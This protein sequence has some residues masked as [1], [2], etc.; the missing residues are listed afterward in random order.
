MAVV[1]ERSLFTLSVPGRQLLSFQG[2]SPFG[3]RFSRTQLQVVSRRNR[4]TFVVA[5]P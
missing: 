1:S 4:L 3:G 2:K 5:M